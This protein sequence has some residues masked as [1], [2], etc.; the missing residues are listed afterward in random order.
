[1]TGVGQ[2][3]EVPTQP[4]LVLAGNGDLDNAVDELVKAILGE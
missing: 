4:D 2:E 3:Y 1:M